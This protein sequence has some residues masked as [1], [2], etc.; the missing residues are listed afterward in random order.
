MG[1]VG[2]ASMRP[3]PKRNAVR[4]LLVGKQDL[5][6]AAEVILGRLD[7]A[8]LLGGSNVQYKAAEV[9]LAAS[10]WLMV[11][12]QKLLVG[13]YGDIFVTLLSGARP[14]HKEGVP[15]SLLTS[16]VVSSA[17]IGVFQSSKPYGADHAVGLQR[18]T[19]HIYCMLFGQ[20]TMWFCQLNLASLVV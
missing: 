6:Q 3:A 18:C 4:E 1:K 2:Q 16:D 13:Q 20:C 19:S 7:I 9:C 15:S 5:K 11:S 12:T 14:T 8:D 17:V 10:S